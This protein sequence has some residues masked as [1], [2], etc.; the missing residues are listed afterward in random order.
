[1]RKNILFIIGFIFVLVSIPVAVFLVKQNQ[2]LREHAAGLN[3]TATPNPTTSPQET[4]LNSNEWNFLQIINSYRANLGLSTLKVSVKLEQASKWEANDLAVAGILSHTDSLGRDPNARLQAFGYNSSSAAENV[5]ASSSDAQTAFNQFISAC[6]P[7]S[8]GA[9]QY[10]HKANIE[11]PEMNAIGIAAQAY[12][13]GQF[14]G[15]YVW[16]TDFGSVVD[17]AITPPDTI[18]QSPTG[19][20]SPTSIIITQEPSPTTQ[21]VLSENPTSKPTLSPTEALQ[22]PTAIPTGISTPTLTLT[23]TASISAAPTISLPTETSTPTPTIANPGGIAQTYSII[24]GAII[25]IIGG[26]FLLAL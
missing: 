18:S 23:P 21:P 12:T 6:D 5:A 26:L 1:V 4:T 17:S 10:T 20:P 11:K 7:D 3:P 9:C 25:I 13:T 19:E 2:D 8:S 14:Q 15:S 24:A 22:T 16:V